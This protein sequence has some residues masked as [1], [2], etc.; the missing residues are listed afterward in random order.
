MRLES[1]TKRIIFLCVVWLIGSVLMAV[2]T[3]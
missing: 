1:D 2:M 3:A